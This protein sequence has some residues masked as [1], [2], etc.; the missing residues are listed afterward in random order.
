MPQRLSSAT[1][2]FALLV[3]WMALFTHLCEISTT[4]GRNTTREQILVLVFFFPTNYVW[5]WSQTRGKIFP[6]KH[7]CI[8]VRYV[9]TA[10]HTYNCN[11][12]VHILCVA[13]RTL[14]F[15]T[16]PKH[17]PPKSSTILGSEAGHIVV[18][19]SLC[20]S[21]CLPIYPSIC[22]SSVYG[23]V[24]PSVCPSVSL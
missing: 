23:Y 2:D 13:T 15:Y 24:H 22:L 7:T 9:T 8:V 4:L 10:R 14:Y 20:L 21:I 6:I 17:F 11:H 16:Y 1:S 12:I 5:L 18:S 3:T 19:T